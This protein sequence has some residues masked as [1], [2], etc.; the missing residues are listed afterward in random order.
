MQAGDIT[1]TL[2]G[3]PVQGRPDETVLSVA[4]RNGVRIP[5]LCFHESVAPYGVCRLCVVEVFW[6]KR[7]KLVTSCVYTPSEGDVVEANNERVRRARR[8]IL[9]LLLARSPDA[10]VVRDLAREYGVDASRFPRPTGRPAVSDRCILCGLCVRVCDEAV[11]VAAI[12]FE[13]RG[14]ARTISTPFRSAAEDCTGCGACVFVCPTGA[15]HFED[16]NGRRNMKELDAAIPLVSCR[17][18]G[19]PFATERQ[20]ARICER[21]HLPAESAEICPACRAAA[22]TGIVGE[23]LR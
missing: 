17:T 9:E 3:G 4:R 14:T 1:F 20:I 7:S 23:L 18:C 6:K 16:A 8:M 12:G 22:T 5:T 2:D 15:L 11:G 13:G 21:L 10:E 19:R